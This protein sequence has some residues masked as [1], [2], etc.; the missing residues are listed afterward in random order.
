[1]KNRDEIL[2]RASALFDEGSYLH[3]LQLYISL[4]ERNIF[5]RTLVIGII[6]VYEK[7]Y[8]PDAISK[9]ARQFELNL[10]EDSSTYN[11]VMFSLLKNNLIE[12][13]DNLVDKGVDSKLKNY[14]KGVIAFEQK[15]YEISVINL[16]EFIEGNKKSVYLPE[17]LYYLAESYFRLEK[18]DESYQLAK[19]ADYF[20]P[21]DNR[22]KTLLTQV[23]FELGMIET[24]IKYFKDIVKTDDERYFML[25]QKLGS[26][27]NKK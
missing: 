22:V 15:D 20:L 12:A 25:S 7:L 3:A 8:R 13:A 10:V 17:A 27:H 6:S 18:F 4:L 11:L 16:R 19:E 1:M 14:F 26:G 24:A 2:R 23:C 9:F 5:D 21:E